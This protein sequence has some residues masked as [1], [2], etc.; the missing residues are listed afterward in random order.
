MNIHEVC[1]KLDSDLGNGL[2]PEEA[3]RRLGIHGP[4][5]LEEPPPRSVFSMFLS[6]IK[7]I[8]VVILIAAALISAIMG[9]WFELAAILVIV[10]LNAAL[11]VFQ[12]YKAEKAIKALKELTRPLAKVVR[13]GSVA[14]VSAD[15]LVPGDVVILEAGDAVPA[16]A[17]LVETVSLRTNE[18]ALTGESVRVEKDAALVAT[19]EVPL[20]D[21]KNMVFIGTTVA[22]GRGKALVVQTGMSLLTGC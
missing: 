21:R 16:D 8:L 11:G 9:E 17:R 20:A 7:E 14:L 10:A 2:S 19:G 4:N 12:E 5:A 3:E 6:Q 1:E 18:A 15:K 13:G 22:G